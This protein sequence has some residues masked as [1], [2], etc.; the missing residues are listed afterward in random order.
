M[1][2]LLNPL[3]PVSSLVFFLSMMAYPAALSVRNYGVGQ[4][5]ASRGH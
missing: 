3:S 2:R 5:D 1:A 4:S